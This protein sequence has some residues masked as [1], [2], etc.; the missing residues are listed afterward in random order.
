MLNTAEQPIRDFSALCR[1]WRN[2]RKLSQLDLAMEAGVSQRHICW[3]ETSRSQP[4]R[5]MVIRLAEALDMPLRE[6]NLF[7]TS[8]GYSQMYQERQLE[9]PAMTAVMEAI[10]TVLQH[11]NPLPAMVIDRFWN[12]R[13]LNKGA[14]L[15]FSLTGDPEE[16][17]RSVRDNGERNLALLTL[18]PN[19]LRRFLSNW[20]EAAP[21]FV[22]RLRREVHMS[23]SREVQSK[24][25]SIISSAGS[26][27][28]SS[29]YKNF[30]TPVLPL[31][32]EAN[33]VTLGLFSVI[34]NFG[35]PQDVTAE[36]LRIETFYPSDKFTEQ[37][38]RAAIG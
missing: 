20:N 21:E 31:M 12:I 36:E 10:S 24:I 28:K 35:T 33:G 7:L 32:F 11:H 6:R 30:L 37:L 2:F 25:D 18:H 26:L 3:L 16:L 5:D 34:S 1:H 17:W 8:A 13:M 15:L 4:S 38:F 29:G 19:G 14:E 27:P 23:G 9:E 22:R